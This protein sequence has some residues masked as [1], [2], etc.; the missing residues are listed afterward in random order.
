MEESDIEV[1]LQRARQCHPGVTPRIISDNGPQFIAKDFKEFIRI[2]G[3]THV[4]TSPYYP[5]SNGKIERWHKTLKG[6][7]IRVSVPMSLE[8][9]RRIVRD[10]VTHYNTARLH[11]AIGY[12]TPKDKLEVEQFVV[13]HAEGEAVLLGRQAV[14]L[15]PANMRC[16][17]ADQHVGH[18]HVKRTHGATPLISIEHLLAKLR[19]AF[20]TGDVFQR[21]THRVED[22]LVQ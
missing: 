17:K 7:S 20:H 22:F 13:H 11:S 16:I 8:D 4:K 19:I 12:I 5:Q 6:E 18:S 14:E 9:A 21:E 3:M 2:A 10:Y 15:V 1:I